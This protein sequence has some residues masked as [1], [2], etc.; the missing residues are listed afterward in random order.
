MAQRR[1]PTTYNLST[2]VLITLKWWYDKV[3]KQLNYWLT[4]VI[5]AKEKRYTHTMVTLV[6][7]F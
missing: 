7:H 2:S 5:I 1:L 3:M 6:S 4:A